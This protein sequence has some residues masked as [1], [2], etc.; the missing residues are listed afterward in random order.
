ML[1]TTYYPITL[2]TKTTTECYLHHVCT[3]VD[4]SALR[5]MYV[6]TSTKTGHAMLALLP[7]VES[8][9]CISS[10][11]IHRPRYRGNATWLNRVHVLDDYSVLTYVQYSSPYTQNLAT[12]KVHQLCTPCC[13]LI[14]G[15]CRL[16]VTCC[17]I[18]LQHDL[19]PKLQQLCT[20]CTIKIL[21]E[22]G[23]E[24]GAHVWET[25]RLPLPHSGAGDEQGRSTMHY[26]AHASANWGR[27]K[28]K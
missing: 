26:K 7:Y 16:V 2:R 24:P 3:Y 15:D 5:Y 8:A 1:Y 18:I 21:P 6:A 9:T 28:N 11:I 22:P 10:L 17:C 27:K 20:T 12:P 13:A 19:T 4:R 23:I 14:D 25:G